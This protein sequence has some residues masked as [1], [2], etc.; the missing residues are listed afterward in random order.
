MIRISSRKRKTLVAIAFLLPNILGFTAFILI[1]LLL[2][3][4]LSF[5]DWNI[6]RH[7]IFHSDSLRFIGF[8]NFL[9]LYGD[10][11][12]WQ[13]LGNTFFFMMGLPFAVIGS[14][15]AALMLTRA[16]I[17]PRSPAI[18]VSIAAVLMTFSGVTFLVL[19]ASEMSIVTLFLL[20]AGGI[21]LGGIFSGGI[22]YRTLFYLPHFTA[23]VATFVLWKKLYNPHVGPIN[24]GL[25]VILDGVS[26]VALSVPPL[27]TVVLPV[28][29]FFGLMA[30]TL[31]QV[32]RLVRNWYE[33]T[34]GLNG[35]IAG[36]L[37]PG[38]ALGLTCYWGGL[39][40][41][42]AVLAGGICCVSL[43]VFVISRP[44]PWGVVAPG[45]GIGTELTLWMVFVPVTSIAALTLAQGGQM[46]DLAREGISPP[47]WLAEYHWAKPA[48]MIMALWAAIGS[49]NMILYLAG[50]GNISPELYEAADIDGASASQRFRFITWPQLAP[51]TFF[52]VVMGVIHGLQ[53]GFEMART[54]TEG[55]PAGAT[56]TLSYFIFIGGFETGAL[57]YASAAAWVLFALVF[58]FSLINFK[59][60]NVHDSY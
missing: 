42:M 14:L 24:Q 59:F 6:L 2:S 55:G 34:T 7:N 23:G 47:N 46:P 11:L 44:R 19:G 49:N 5:T 4:G 48:L 9:R 38:M 35:V 1:P 57:G 32:R 36:L 60:G 22:L 39:L 43:V 31:W 51:V 18:A 40:R 37:W 20:L 27:F 15:A 28:L 58:F 30:A 53:G 3:F 33:A 54:M 52:I 25:E 16:T 17:R 41:E 13:S 50:L 56:T 12:F 8:D 10:P 21:F 26:A 29:A 45:K